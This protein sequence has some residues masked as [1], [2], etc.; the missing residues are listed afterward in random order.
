MGSTGD[1]RC[2][3]DLLGGAPALNGI[4]YRP[5][6]DGLRAVA[7]AAV[8]AFHAELGVAPGGFV[9]VE[10]FFVISGYLIT[11]LI[12]ADVEA[13]RFS[14]LAFYERRIRRIFPALLAVIAVC[15]VVGYWR[16]TP[17]DFVLLGRNALAALGFHS[18][19]F[20]AGRAGYFMPN[21]DA[22]PLLHTWSL[23]VEEQFYLLAPL[24]LLL[25]TGAGRRVVGLA[26]WPLLA[27]AIAVSVAGVSSN[28]DTAFYLFQTRAF[29]LMIGAAL[30]LSLMPHIASGAAREALS[31]AGLLMIVAAVVLYTPLTVFPGFAALLPC[32]GAALLI[33]CARDG[34][35]V[36][37]AGRMLA[38]PP[39]VTVGLVSYS[40]YLWHW[41]LLAFAE[42]EW[43][44]QV[45]WQVRLALCAVAVVMAFASYRWIEQPARKSR[46]ILTRSRVFAGGIGIALVL[47][48]FS[49]AIVV[50]H[51]LPSRLAP[52]IAAFA[53][54]ISR[55]RN[56]SSP[57]RTRS[58]ADAREICT[59]GDAAATPSFLVWGDSHA[60]SLASEIH[61]L[62][63]S[64]GV[65]GYLVARG[66]CPPI[67]EA[68]AMPELSKRKCRGNVE[69]VERAIENGS[70]QN[71]LLFARWSAY[72]EVRKQASSPEAPETDD[73]EFTRLLSA[74]VSH[75]VRK[76]VN[77]TIIGPVPELPLN[78][79]TAMIKGRMKGDPFKLEL[80]YAD[81]LA[82]QRRV[83]V[84]L[85]G[86][87]K[88]PKVNVVYPH[89]SLCSDRH[90]TVVEDD[91]PLYSDDNHLN[92]RGTAKLA[93]LL[94]ALLN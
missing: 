15:L 42:Y 12:V 22:L 31:L 58:S 71:V 57:C 62:A 64:R 35:S 61:S 79:P 46:L 23:G 2:R 3:A 19:F 69:R 75:L 38:T 87:S 72:A 91:F 56:G 54:E 47:A 81:F 82:H 43:P 1:G 27:V 60:L 93:Q 37:V 63:S 36:T 86:L 39:F 70:V 44:E 41:P 28:A 11:S 59:L 67:L 65:A 51:G 50:S 10:V 6:I 83:L 66:G 89:L 92:W 84:M 68:G 45:S 8:V 33:H 18:N 88:L 52:D 53:E 74:T 55:A 24:L 32:L 26:F 85:E 25:G 34:E 77:V 78:L 20:L 94:N 9:G 40:L 90:C 49:H 48:A 21:S 73:N 4:R 17:D 29:E 76:G 5:E 7:V 16:M 14:I 30:G 80:D 13:G